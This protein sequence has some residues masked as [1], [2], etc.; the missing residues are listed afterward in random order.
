[1]VP[2]SYTARSCAAPGGGTGPRPW[3]PRAAATSAA[4]A[5]TAAAFESGE[6]TSVAARGKH[7]MNT[8]RAYHTQ[9]FSNTRLRRTHLGHITYSH[10]VIC[11]KVI[12]GISHTGIGSGRICR[13]YFWHDRQKKC[14]EI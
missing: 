2:A 11:A 6:H 10:L 3:S 4:T 9:E 12:W 8:N 1:M 7:T 13:H 14:R 5:A